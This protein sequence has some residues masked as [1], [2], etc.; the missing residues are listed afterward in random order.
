MD[1]FECS[2]NGIVDQLHMMLITKGVDKDERDREN[3]CTALHYAVM[4]QQVEAVRMLLNAGVNANVEDAEARTPLLYVV[5]KNGVMDLAAVLAQELLEHGADL[6]HRSKEGDTL[7]HLAA[8]EGYDELL[9]YLLSDFAGV[10][11][12]DEINKRGETPLHLAAGSGRAK[13]VHVL[14]DHNANPN[15]LTNKG[16][17]PLS[18]AKPWPALKQEIETAAA[19]A[20]KIEYVTLQSGL[21]IRKDLL[22]VSFEQVSS[23]LEQDKKTSV[24]GAV[25]V[26]DHG[27]AYSADGAESNA[28]TAAFDRHVGLNLHRSGA[29]QRRRSPQSSH[30]GVS[31]VQG[32]RL[33]TDRQTVSDGMTDAGLAFMGE[34]VGAMSKA[35]LAERIAAE[36]SAE[37]TRLVEKERVRVDQRLRGL[38]YEGLKRKM[39]DYKGEG[40]PVQAVL[41][42]RD[43][44]SPERVTTVG[45][46]RLLSE[47]GSPQRHVATIGGMAGHHAKVEELEE[48]AE[49]ITTLKKAGFRDTAKEMRR[50][51]R[52]ERRKERAKREAE[53]EQRQQEKMGYRDA[54][55]QIGEHSREL[56][57]EDVPRLVPSGTVFTLRR[58]VCPKGPVPDNN[59]FGAINKLEIQ[60]K[61]MS[62]QTAELTKRADQ[63]R[64]VQDGV[65]MAVGS[66]LQTARRRAAP[67]ANGEGGGHEFTRRDNRVLEDLQS[68][69]DHL[70]GLAK[71][72][73]ITKRKELLTLYRIQ[74]YLVWL[75]KI[76]ALVTVVAYIWAYKSAEAY[77]PPPLW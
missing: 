77:L 19:R 27:S 51:E 72:D 18:M 29:S 47:G 36:K 34:D 56:L 71:K 69:I 64:H 39:A 4:E 40:S 28:T 13:A 66:G 48:L 63:L 44:A 58:L 49:E 68:R 59:L 20:P 22:P 55:A 7:L 61:E 41:F 2:R 38:F 17:T 21:V 5:T 10:V 16:W 26:A 73:I 11:D 24:S 6:T 12:V 42:P 45:V 52:K 67:A 53:K 14:L 33:Y 46:D 57:D 1:I 74:R 9:R 8:K 43:G 50:M 25:Q 15:R 31:T 65:E 70:E 54:Q 37:Q 76:V 32:R 23:Q 3:G 35:E 60:L 75:V 30:A 62:K